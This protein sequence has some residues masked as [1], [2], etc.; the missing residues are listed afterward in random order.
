LV[1]YNSEAGNGARGAGAAQAAFGYFRL[2]DLLVA[3][4]ACEEFA[5]HSMLIQTYKPTSDGSVA[6]RTAGG[7]LHRASKFGIS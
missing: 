3:W 7:E 2:F 6:A 5:A 1:C 4:I